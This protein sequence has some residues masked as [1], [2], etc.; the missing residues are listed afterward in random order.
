ML[1][2]TA[3]AAAAA[4]AAAIAATTAAGMNHAMMGENP[5]NRTDHEV[6]PSCS[7]RAS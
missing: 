1:T 5:S 2:N 3:A 6:V 7:H 4:A